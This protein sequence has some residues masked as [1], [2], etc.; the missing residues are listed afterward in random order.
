ML[1]LGMM[2]SFIYTVWQKRN[3]LIVILYWMGFDITLWT[4]PLVNAFQLTIVSDL[5]LSSIKCSNWADVLFCIVVSTVIVCGTIHYF[6]VSS[7]CN[8]SP[9]SPESWKFIIYIFLKSYRFRK[10]QSFMII[11]FPS[12]CYLHISIILN[13]PWICINWGIILMFVV[14]TNGFVGLFI[15]LLLDPVL[16]S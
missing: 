6:V 11:Y 16:G 15:I 2:N 5:P 7:S 14:L 10:I 12:I 9:D 1:Y 4:K 8:V 3:V 13:L